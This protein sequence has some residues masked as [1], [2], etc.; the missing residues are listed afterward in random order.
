LVKGELRVSWRLPIFVVIIVGLMAVKA[1]LL[2]PYGG[3]YL[4]KRRED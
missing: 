4:K 3:E 2:P 1:A